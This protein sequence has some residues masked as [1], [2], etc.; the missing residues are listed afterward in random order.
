MT[1]EAVAAKYNLVAAG[2]AAALAFSLY[3]VMSLV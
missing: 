2:E 3:Q 1:P